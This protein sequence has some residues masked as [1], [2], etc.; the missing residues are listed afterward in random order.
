MVE[1]KIAKVFR[2]LGIIEGISG[3]LLTFILFMEDDQYIPFAIMLF[4]VA[5][6]NCFIFLGFGEIID[7]LQKNV[8]NQHEMVKIV[9]ASLSDDDG[10]SKI[11]LE[12][13]EKNLPI[14]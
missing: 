14:I 13:I 7:L 5:L 8:D 12:D 6:V 10:A 3:L 2:V 11:L 4:V 9:K 1:N